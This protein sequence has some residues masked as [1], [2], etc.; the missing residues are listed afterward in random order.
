MGVLVDSCGGLRGG[1]LA[2]SLCAHLRHGD[3]LARALVSRTL[4]RVCGPLVD[5]VQ[6]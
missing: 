2:S 1:A 4:R 3:P 6:R 5:M